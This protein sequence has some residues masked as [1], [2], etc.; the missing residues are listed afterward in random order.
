MEEVGDK[1]VSL[2]SGEN[3]TGPAVY[4]D[5]TN[6]D[7]TEGTYVGRITIDDDGKAFKYFIKNESGSYNEVNEGDVITGKSNEA[8][9]IVAL[10]LLL[11]SVISNW[12]I[13]AIGFKKKK[14]LT[15]DIA[16]GD[17]IKYDFSEYAIYGDRLVSALVGLAGGLG[18]KPTPNPI[19]NAGIGAFGGATV[20][21]MNTLIATYAIKLIADKLNLPNIMKSGISLSRILR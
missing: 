6:V 7:S 8:V 17:S 10:P 2:I 11:Q 9:V 3:T 1:M 12:I 16:V 14:N 19:L 20:G 21:P 4:L 13:T 18:L 5:I 15:E